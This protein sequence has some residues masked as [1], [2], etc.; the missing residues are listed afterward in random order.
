MQGEEL[1]RLEAFS[2]DLIEA[3]ISIGVPPCPGGMASRMSARAHKAPI[4]VGP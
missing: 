2:N 3:L 4:P 1:A